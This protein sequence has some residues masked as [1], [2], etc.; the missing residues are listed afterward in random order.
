VATLLSSLIYLLS[1]EKT[2]VGA[3]LLTPSPLVLPLK[4]SYIFLFNR[5]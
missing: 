5:R 1:D 3:V 4:P 2:V